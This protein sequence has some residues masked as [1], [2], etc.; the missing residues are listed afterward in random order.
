[1]QEHVRLDSP[2][3]DGT[4]LRDHLEAAEAAIG[5]TLFE[6]IDIPAEAEH[7]WLWFWE[8]HA[9]RGSTG[10]GPASI[11]Y[12]DIEAWSRLCGTE[13]SPWEVHT[14]RQMDNA[15]LAAHSTPHR[16]KDKTATL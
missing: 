12:A 16:K 4:T 8:L 6:E 7:L 1:M 3:A 11:G 14:L 13:P 15:Y 10:W 5:E 2:H 9:G